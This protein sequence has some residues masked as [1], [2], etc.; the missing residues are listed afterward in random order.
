MREKRRTKGEGGLYQRHDHPRCPAEEVVE[1]RKVRPDHKCH[2]SW[3]GVV[4][5]G[6]VDGKRVRRTVTAATLKEVRPKFAALK[7]RTEA[8]VT[9][10]ELSVGS[11][12]ELWLTTIAPRRTRESTLR[13]YRGYVRTWIAPHLGHL[14]LG[15]MQP[16]HAEA[17]YDAMRQAGRKDATVRQAHAIL[18]KAYKDAVRRKKVVRSPMDIAE[19]P[20]VPK[21]HHAYLPAHEAKLVMLAA[22]GPE[23]RA[24][25]V[26]AIML[27]LRQG[28]ALGLRW[29]DVAL[30]LEHEVGVLQVRRAVQ[31]VTGQGLVVTELKTSRSERDVPL[32][33][34]VVRAFAAWRAESGGQGYVFGGEKPVEPRTDYAR[35]RRALDRAGVNPVPLHGARASGASIMRELG[36]PENVIA[37]ILGHS[38]VRTTM[39]HYLRSDE[40]Q[41]MEALSR[42]GG[43]LAV[44]P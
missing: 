44:D 16:E 43:L 33:P 38:N 6:W 29:T 26:A 36:V 13:S 1:G 12:L 10:A 11:W 14:P 42:L 28:E 4:D 18:S 8:G 7:E 15:K 23:Q 19:P 2:G 39:A 40:A 5:L 31:R 25:L 27:G 22:E 20:A 41:R 9:S 37:D 3:V 34:G 21:D 30:D 24:R 32:I 35:W 17:M